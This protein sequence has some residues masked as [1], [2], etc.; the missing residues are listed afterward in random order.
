MTQTRVYRA[1]NGQDFEVRKLRTE[2]SF[3]LAVYHY[4]PMGTYPWRPLSA[5]TRK[6][7]EAAIDGIVH[8]I[9]T[10]SKPSSKASSQPTD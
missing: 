10:A 2:D 6:Q 3:H 1:P 9:A 4:R 8:A 5:D 7:A